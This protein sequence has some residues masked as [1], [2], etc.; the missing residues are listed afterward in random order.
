MGDFL[1]SFV[2][3]SMDHSKDNLKNN[4]LISKLNYFISK[5]INYFHFLLIFLVTISHLS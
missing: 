5:K 3:L 4:Y 2:C 1:E